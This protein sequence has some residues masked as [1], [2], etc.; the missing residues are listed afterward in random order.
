M[1][2]LVFHENEVK[3]Y[4]QEIYVI[5]N[6]SRLADIIPD[7]ELQRHSGLRCIYLFGIDRLLSSLRSWNGPWPYD[8]R[9]QSGI[10]FLPQPGNFL[11]K[12]PLKLQIWPGNSGKCNVITFGIEL[13][14]GN[15]RRIRLTT[16]LSFGRCIAVL[17][18]IFVLL[19]FLASRGSWLDF[20]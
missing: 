13:N 12:Q 19:L 6:R 7:G 4:F 9:W 8:C 20:T 10:P 17:L 3:H 16:D 1:Y 15:G 14:D 5:G 2:C 18:L 11:L